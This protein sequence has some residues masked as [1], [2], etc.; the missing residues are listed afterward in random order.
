MDNFYQGFNN[1]LTNSLWK[2]NF[3][4]LSRFSKAL[5]II[6]SCVILLL[7]PQLSLGLS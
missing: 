1:N 2:Q 3:S 4:C 5:D 7:L 6:K